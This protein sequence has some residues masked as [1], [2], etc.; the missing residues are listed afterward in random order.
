MKTAPHIGQ[1]LKRYV[2]EKRLFQSGWAREQGI[3]PK[4][5]GNYL[6]RPTMRINTLFTIC[7]VLEYNFFTEIA[8]LLPAELPPHIEQESELQAEKLKQENEQL[9]LQVATLEKALA[10]VGG[11]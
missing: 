9:K 5:I 4:A 7:Q 6:K 8:R 3:S 1:M 2:K 11:R 10:L